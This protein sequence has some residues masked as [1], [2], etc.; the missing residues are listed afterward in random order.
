MA[1]L[2]TL[3]NFA[4]PRTTWANPG[5]G[6]IIEAAGDLFGTTAD[7]VGGAGDEASVYEIANTGTGY[8]SA[9]ATLAIFQNI[10]G[11]RAKRQRHRQ[12]RFP[13]VW[14]C[15]VVLR[16]DERFVVAISVKLD[17]DSRPR[18]APRQ[19]QAAIATLGDA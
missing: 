13:L 5:S 4:F 19:G 16:D 8:A 6:L 14:Y 9:P 2:I 3:V 15:Q 18:A 7:N 10:A 12:N 17:D 11:K 1:T